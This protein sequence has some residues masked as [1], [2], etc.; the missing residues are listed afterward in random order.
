MVM[1]WEWVPHIT[2]VPTD[3]LPAPGAWAVVECCW[4]SS[5]IENAKSERTLLFALAQHE[6]FDHVDALQ[7]LRTDLFV[8]DL[9][10]KGFLKKR[11]QAEDTQRINNSV[12][13]QRLIVAHQSDAL[14]TGQFLTDE[15]AYLIFN[16]GF[17]CRHCWSSW[18][19][20]FE[21]LTRLAGTP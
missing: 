14:R 9:Y 16:G 17:L 13:D 11:Y 18:T 21:L 5:N 2:A 1:G 12:F 8:A 15:L 6:L 3:S 10:S 4:V 7:I 19:S 20:N